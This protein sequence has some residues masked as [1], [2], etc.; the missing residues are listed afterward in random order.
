MADWSESIAYVLETIG[1]VRDGLDVGPN[2]I[3]IA[4][5]LGSMRSRSLWKAYTEFCLVLQIRF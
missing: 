1:K 5:V 4:R 3:E 2:E